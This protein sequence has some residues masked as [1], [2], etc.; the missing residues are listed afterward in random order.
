MVVWGHT[1]PFVVGFL[2]VTYLVGH[3]KC[4]NNTVLLFV[5]DLC[6]SLSTSH[7]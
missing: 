6:M 3:K 2:Y 5:H 4:S 7:D 1:V